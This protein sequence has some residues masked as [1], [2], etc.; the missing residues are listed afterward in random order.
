MRIAF[1]THEYPGARPG[2]IGSYTLLVAQAL[3]AAG[4]EPHVFTLTLP[5]AARDAAPAGVT[6][7]ETPDLAERIASQ[8]LPESLAGAALAAGLG[9][10][11]LALAWLLTECVRDVHARSPFDIVEAPEYEALGLPLM[12]HPAPRLPV[13]TQAHLGSAINRLGNRQ[14]AT[15]E[16]PAS[17]NPP[18]GQWPHGQSDHGAD[19][20]GAEQ[21]RDDAEPRHEQGDGGTAEDDELPELR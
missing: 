20:A 3:A 9:A 14:P 10:Y 13:V 1:I 17:P 18:L 5:K 7:H 6:L 21:D 12:I 16:P 11:K 4:H 15:A 8:T 2:G 19:R